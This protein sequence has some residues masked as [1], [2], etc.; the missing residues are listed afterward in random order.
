MASTI[1]GHVRYRE[2][3]KELDLLRYGTDDGCDI[4]SVS[5]CELECELLSLKERLESE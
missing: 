2:I 3:E 5:I 1:S 4:N